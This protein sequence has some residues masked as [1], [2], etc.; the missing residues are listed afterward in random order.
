MPSSAWGSEGLGDRGRDYDVIVVGAGHAG[1]EAALAAAR[2]GVSTLMLTINLES[3]ALMPCNPAVGGPAKGH[4]V[5]EI[6]ALGGAMG[7]VADATKLQAR[8]LN[9]G[10]GPAVQALRVQSDKRAYQA[11]MRRVLERTRGLDLK[12]AMVEEVLVEHGRF[13]GFRTAS[14]I[15][16]G[17]K[18]GVLTGGVYLNS[19]VIVGD[20][21]YDSGPSGLMASHGLSS[22]LERLGLKLGRFKTGTP[23][24]I[25]KE[26]ID[27]GALVEQPGSER[28][29]CFS[30][31][32]GCVAD[33]REQLPCW[34]TY[35]NE[36][37]HAIIR[38]NLH[39]A[40]LY[41]GVIQGVGPRYCPSVE[42]KV[43]RFAD[44]PRHPIFIE[45]EGRD[46]R[47]MYVL[48]FSTSLPEDVQLEALRTI[49]GLER[50]EIMR[51]G[52]AIEYD[53]LVPTQLKRTLEVKSIEGLYSAGQINGTS[54]YEE[55][56]AQGLV[57]GANAAL[58]I[59]GR[60]PLILD[61]SEA[62]VGVLIDDLV[63]KGTN[64]PYRML[65]ARAEYRLLLRQDNADLRLTRKGREL[66]L[67][68]EDQYRGFL[69]RE[70]AIGRE[71][72]R[73]KMTTVR[74]SEEVQ[75]YLAERGS[76]PLRLPVSLADLLLRP[77]LDYEGLAP[78]DPGRPKLPQGVGDEVEVEIKY[79]GYIK[80]QKA[81]VER[82]RKLEERRLPLDLDY[83]QVYGLSTEARQKLSAVRPETVGQAGRI[84]GVS[85]ADISLLLVY[86]E[87]E[88][89]KG[90]AGGG[91]GNAG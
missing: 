68:S 48:G 56:A 89:R 63:T 32:R 34:L 25:D 83:G 10:K 67:V 6:D 64:E 18:A 59:I 8:L 80:K 39:R 46:T 9:T 24:R 75:A 30:Y 4:L 44:K 71:I 41:T 29:L 69:A 47:E 13:I 20:V 15:I 55:A 16:Y 84:S 7:R 81:Q 78:L 52:Y 61:R 76:A 28:P 12:Q 87:A 85:P 86:L 1:C 45:P 72:E 40:P 27:F 82:M 58:K 22:S 51:P 43:V 65:T 33:G 49:R 37:T 42:D 79:A 31:L 2:L 38:A 73:L 74:P 17:A 3:I 14:G 90:K 66:G 60:P 36:R 19:R 70:E 91:G 35:T 26:S 23:P 88:G 53:Y 50:A 21:T 11:E 5:R 77:E 62:Y 54:G 57:A